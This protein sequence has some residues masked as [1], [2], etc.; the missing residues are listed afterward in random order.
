MTQRHR[1][2]VPSV[3]VIVPDAFSVDIV[4]GR[5]RLLNASSAKDECSDRTREEGHPTA[6]QADVDP[7][8]WIV[9]DP[10]DGEE[11]LEQMLD[12][13]RCDTELVGRE[14]DVG[15]SGIHQDHRGSGDTRRT[16]RDHDERHDP[17]NP[18]CKH[19]HDRGDDSDDARRKYDQA[20]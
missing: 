4:F 14:I 2:I 19:E 7:H 8:R 10:A 17:R 13:S 1:G 3:F 15:I 11:R 20:C 6:R 9:L 12:V 5:F 18:R 16:C